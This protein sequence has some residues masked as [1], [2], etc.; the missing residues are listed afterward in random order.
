[1][2]IEVRVDI[3]PVSII[4]NDGIGWQWLP[5]EIGPS[6]LEVRDIHSNIVAE[7]PQD[8]VVYVRVINDLSR[9]Q[10]LSSNFEK[11][12]PNEI[13]LTK[14]M[15]VTGKPSKPELG[16]SGPPDQPTNPR[17]ILIG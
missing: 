17:P 6:L 13:E 15:E 9:Q 11:N 4:L 1:M 14:N 5:H 3:E 7:F 8:R 12:H 2:P 16:K 10:E